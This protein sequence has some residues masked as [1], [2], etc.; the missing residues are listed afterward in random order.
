MTITWCRLSTSTLHGAPR[1]IQS[2]VALPHDWVHT[3]VCH[4][5]APVF[6]ALAKA[7]TNVNF[8]KCDVDAAKDVAGQYSVTA[9]YA[10]SFF[11]PCPSTYS[12]RGPHSYS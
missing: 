11:S 10:E 9:M 3:G 8:L 2:V 7:H 1:P 6:E 4:M 5:I 12:L